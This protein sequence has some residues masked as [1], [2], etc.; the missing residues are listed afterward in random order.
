MYFCGVIRVALIGSGNL[1]HHL[2]GALWEAPMVDFCQWMARRPEQIRPPSPQIPIGEIR[3]PSQAD[4]CLLA[5]SDR[6][7][8][9]L[10]ETLAPYSGL[11]AHTS[12][13]TPMDHLQACS[14]RGVFYPLQTFTA[15]QHTPLEQVPFLLEAAS[16]QDLAL[17]ETLATALGGRPVHATSEA[18][19]QAH[20][21]A[22]FANNFSNHMIALGQ[23]LCRAYHLDP[24]ILGPVTA[25]T[26]AKLQGQTARQAQTGPARRGDNPTLER[27]RQLLANTPLKD[28][29][30]LITHSIQTTY[31]DKL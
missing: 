7:I 26:F 11:V 16:I 20:L 3:E 22:V 1:A 15:G 29:Y 2:G 27:H 30:N 5:V 6:A 17:L 8:S 14:N 28:L 19:S 12:G 24:D 18:R 9:A 10:A 25:Q 4:I 21:A 13:A 23:E 31:E